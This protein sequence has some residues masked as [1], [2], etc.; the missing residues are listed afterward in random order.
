MRPRTS[1]G[2]EGLLTDSRKE[3]YG[4]QLSPDPSC[5]LS[6][7][8]FNWTPV[9]GAAVFILAVILWVTYA[10]T[11]YLGPVKTLT[12]QESYDTSSHFKETTGRA[13][14]GNSEAKAIDSNGE[15]RLIGEA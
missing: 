11:R 8:T 14:P 9:S 2:L 10:R 5:C 13:R 12:T 15:A 6:R 3:L 7:D 4:W 1:S